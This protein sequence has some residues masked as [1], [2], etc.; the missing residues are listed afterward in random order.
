MNIS[1]ALRFEQQASRHPNRAALSFGGKVMT[2]EELNRRSEVLLMRLRLMGVGPG[3]SV[4][5]LLERSFELIVSFIAILKAGAAYVPLDCQYPPE[6]LCWMVTDSSIKVLLTS[7]D[8]AGKMP[9]GTRKNLLVDEMDWERTPMPA[10]KA[11]PSEDNSAAGRCAYIMYTSGSTGIPKGVAIPHRGILRLVCEPD[12]VDIGLGD[13][14]LQSSPVSFDASTFEIWGALLNGARLAIPPPGQLSLQSIATIIRTEKVTVLWLTAGLFN[15]MVDERL[16][17]LKPVR[18]LLAGGEALSVPHVERAL[19]A[20]DGTQLINGYGPTENTT[21]TCCYRIPKNER[22]AH[23]VPI[24]RPIRG[25]RVHIVNEMLQEVP[26][27]MVG[28]LVTGGQGLALGYWNRPELTQERFVDDPFSSHA[29]TKLYRT[30]D[31]VRQRSDGNLEFMGRRDS[32]V[33]VRGFRI[34]PGEVESILKEHPEVRDCAVT[35]S[36]GT[37]AGKFL[38][39]FVVPR[40]ES[41][42]HVDH[43]RQFLAARLPEHMVPT[44]WEFLAQLPLNPN[45]KVDR[46]RLLPSKSPTSTGSFE[47]PGTALEREIASSWREILGE[48][49]FGVA[50][51]F[52]D[53]GGDSLL[54]AQLHDR[55]CARTGLAVM[56]TDLFHFPTVRSL[57]N[58]IERQQNAGSAD[59]V[60]SGSERGRLQRGAFE[61]FRRK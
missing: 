47:P 58:H 51:N 45:G 42:P 21:F 38:I 32:Q 17:D 25:T 18:K 30:G 49:H 54:L 20:L 41:L 8:Q 33:K 29:G 3:D 4:G 59:L 60:S 13:V 34:E 46:A 43:L 35:A 61:R 5:V 31:L 16:E 36:E 24:G 27:G 7:T 52:F 15:L 14:F 44:R 6:R 12:F 23:S 2:Y 48:R 28:E 55:L 50:D 39:G 57:A 26:V 11:P 9:A 56:L 53:V 19:A 10:A 37:H 22:F 40:T 1:V